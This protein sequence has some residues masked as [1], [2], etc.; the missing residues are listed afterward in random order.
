MTTRASADQNEALCVIERARAAGLRLSI[1]PGGGLRCTG[2]MTP[3]I[4]R[5]LIRTK[6][7]VLAV[8]AVS[9]P[10]SDAPPI[11]HV[12]FMW[13]Q[14]M[15]R[16][17][18]TLGP[19]ASSHSQ[20]IEA[21]RDLRQ[22]G[23]LD[24]G[25]PRTGQSKAAWGAARKRAKAGFEK[26]Q[27]KPTAQV[28]AAAVQL[29]LELAE[30]WQAEHGVPKDVM[31]EWMDKLYSGELTARIDESGWPV[32]FGVDESREKVPNGSSRP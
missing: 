14:A 23:L 27:L 24:N 15:S 21:G 13:A 22:R 8:L 3:E 11:E 10:P 26:H 6:D 9:P 4:R 29:E 31:G 12:E 1:A 5:D 7:L 32:L 25:L 18:E 2:A 16:A 20:R 19:E 17:R 28:L 30:G